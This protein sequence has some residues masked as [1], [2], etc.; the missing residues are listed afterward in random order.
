MQYLK[1]YTAN[2]GTILIR[3]KDKTGYIN[4]VP[5]FVWKQIKNK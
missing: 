5:L 2:D 3:Y 4:I 1:S